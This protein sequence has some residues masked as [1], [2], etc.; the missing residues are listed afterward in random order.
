[1][2]LFGA[3]MLVVAS[4]GGLACDPNAGSNA[5]TDG[6]AEAGPAPRGALVAMAADKSG[7]CASCHMEEYEHVRHP[8]HKGVK[9]TTCGVCHDQAGWRPEVLNH[10]WWPLTGAHRGRPDTQCSWCHEGTP[11]VFKGTPKE[12][13]GCHREDF[14]ASKFRDHST[15]STTCTECHTTEAWKPAKHPPKAPAP[16]ATPTTSASAKTAP[17]PKATATPRATAQPTAVPIPIPTTT[18]PPVPTPAPTPVPRPTAVPTTRP[19]DVITRP[20][21]R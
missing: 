17:L 8:P 5:A 13:I 10:D 12:C 7:D 11:V 9:P 18:T 6:G 14:E 3:S 1:M 20:S 4:L 21:K 16:V 15:F 2:R 19:P